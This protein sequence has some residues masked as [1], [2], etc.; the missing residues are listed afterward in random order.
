VAFA[1]SILPALI[2]ALAMILLAVTIGLATG[3]EVFRQ[4]P[5]VALREA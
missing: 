1:P 3:R 4:T 5:M 2:V